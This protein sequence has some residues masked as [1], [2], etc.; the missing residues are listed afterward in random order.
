MRKAILFIIL[1]SAIPNAFS[2][3]Y[4]YIKPIIIEPEFFETP[5]TKISILPVLDERK[6]KSVNSKIKSNFSLSNTIR[7]LTSG[8]LIT[9]KNYRV[10]NLDTYG[11]H[12]AISS[13]DLNRANTTWVKNLGPD[14][15]E[16]AFVLVFSDAQSITTFGRMASVDISAYMYNKKNGK[17]IWKNK[18]IVQSGQGGLY[19][20]MVSH[21]ERLRVTIGKAVRKLLQGL[22]D[23]EMTE[24]SFNA[25]VKKRKSA[26]YLDDF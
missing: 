23:K 19:G 22:P 24:A 7:A 12:K 8:E 3:S 14:D 9:E 17:L 4:K 10:N 16:T 26:D 18:V 6:D 1:F 20:L 25:K 11:A 15:V 13:R 5:I 21:S 2:A